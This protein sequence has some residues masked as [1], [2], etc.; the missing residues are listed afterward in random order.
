MYETTSNAQAE[1]TLT[2]RTAQSRQLTDREKSTYYTYT[3]AVYTAKGVWIAFTDDDCVV[4][5]DWLARAEATLAA[6]GA[7]AE[8]PVE[9][10]RTAALPGQVGQVGAQGEDVKV[11][12]HQRG[13]HRHAPA[14]A[15]KSP[16]QIAIFG[17]ESKT[18]IEPVHLSEGVP[19]ADEVVG[20]Q[21]AGIFGI[22]IPGSK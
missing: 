13:V 17:P 18:L 15:R 11:F 7:D 22:G 10:P 21:K 3:T 9:E 4:P 8:A 19:A 6:A 12:H 14:P 20:G 2:T 16:Y 5:P 1:T